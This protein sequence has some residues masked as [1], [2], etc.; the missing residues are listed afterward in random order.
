MAEGTS[1]KW[2]V[3][4]T[5]SVGDVYID[6]LRKATPERSWRTVAVGGLREGGTSYF[7]VDITAPDKVT[8][9]NL[10]AGKTW[11]PSFDGTFRPSCA[12]DGGTYTSSLCGPV[13]FPY[14]LWEFTDS[15]KNVSTGAA[16]RLDEDANGQPDLGY[17]WSIP[18]IGRIRVQEGTK[19]VDKYVAVVG[20]GFDPNDKLNP[21]RGNWL[22]ILDIE[23]GQAIYKRALTGAAPSEPAA[24][25]TNQDGYFD[26][27]YIGTTLGKMYR[28][29]LGKDASGSYPELVNTSVRG[30]DG[31]MY[32]QARI[33]STS[34][35]PRV[36]FDAMY[37]GTTPL[38]A[39]KAP[40]RA[41]YNRPSVIFVARLGRYALSFGTGD[42]ED[43]WSGDGTVTG[44][45]YIV[46]DDTD[47]LTP[48][49]TLTEANFKRL[50][51]ADAVGSTD[52]LLSN[53]AGQ[54]G[55]YLV[56]DPDER[57]I[58]DPFALSGVSFFST[59]KPDVQVSGGKD[60]LC[61]KTGTSRIFIVSTVNG[62]PFMATRYIQVS[63]FVTN[64]YTE[65]GQTRNDDLSTHDADDFGVDPNS[66]EAKR[67]TQVMNS[68]KSR[69]SSKCK[70][71]NY[72]IDI[73]TISA[74]TGIVF[75]AP[76]PICIMEKNWK[77]VS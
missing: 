3:D 13:P 67:L 33:P 45:F 28:I 48:G 65:Q 40:T 53:T 30:Q 47:D 37:D 43:L 12:G 38:T 29:D 21:K 70:F 42:R 63:T 34:W 26:R 46:V 60:P 52:Y 49:T 61:S 25:D 31:A 59:F 32:T 17:T 27:I 18:N 10:S 69:F 9:Q 74:D 77:D 24:V 64:P 36:V 68:L 44:R 14:I 41:M 76:V 72:R 50:G 6:P 16:V 62:N 8:Q 58:T 35:G 5:V 66:D 11:V 75:I 73:K 1:H 20:G 55:W 7:A 23:T 4:G 22:Y 54:R 56:L 19:V 51:V 57:V 39:D 71:S 15:V 2:G